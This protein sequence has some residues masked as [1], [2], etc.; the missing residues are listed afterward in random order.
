MQFGFM[1]GRH[2]R[3]NLHSTQVTRETPWHKHKPL[4][5]AFVNLEKAF[6]CVPKKVLWWAMRRPGVDEWVIRAVKAMYENAKSCVHV[7]GQFSDKFNIKVSFHQG[8]VLSPLLFLIIM[9]AL[10]R[11]FRVGCPWELLYADDPVLIA[12]TLENLKK[13]LK[14]WKD[15]IEAK[16]LQVNVHKTKPVCSKHNL[17]VKSVPVK[18]SCSFCC[19]GVGI[20]S[21]F[22]QS[23]NH[24]IYKRCSK[25]K[26]SLKADPSF[27]CNACTNNIMTISQDGPEVIIG[28]DKFEVVDS[29]HYLG[30]SIGHS[31]SCFKATTDSESSL[32]E[33]PVCFQY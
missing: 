32:E 26:G 19:K 22:Y 21:T 28:N 20:S 30:D 23:C 1:P 11:E 3:C 8:A 5:F 4:Y 9:E 7:N 25:I 17:P 10:S 6:D 27:K 33:F 18:W 29:F 24:W 15:N 16:G 2:H 31:G 14:V 13:K 12:E